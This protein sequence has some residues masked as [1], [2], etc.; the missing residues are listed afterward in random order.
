MT[1]IEITMAFTALALVLRT[2][3]GGSIITINYRHMRLPKKRKR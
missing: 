1:I 3:K 2:I